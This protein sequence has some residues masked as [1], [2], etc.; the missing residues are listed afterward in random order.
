MQNI[1]IMQYE[2]HFCGPR[3]FVPIAVNVWMGYPVHEGRDYI[4][5]FHVFLVSDRVPLI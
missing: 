3:Y 5:L 2:P 4:G 1:Q